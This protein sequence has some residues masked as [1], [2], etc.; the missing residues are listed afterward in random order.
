MRQLYVLLLLGCAS[1]GAGAP[2]SR[3][4]GAADRV[5]LVD[6]RG[7]VYRTNVS[8][9]EM[10][11]QVVPGTARQTV[12][13]LVGVYESM[14]LSVNTIDWAAGLVGARGVVAPRR[15]VGSALS[16]YLDCGASQMGQLRADSYSLMIDVESWAKPSTPGQMV[17][18]T[19]T[20]GTARARGVSSDPVP[21]TTTSV[22]EKRIHLELARRLAGGT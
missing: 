21:C 15:L 22:L 8:R 17:V 12:E 19:I 6:E 18:S 3:T 20:K 13:A 7:R 1:G 4:A 5:L 11:E 9:V 2:A 16:T 14:G 10:P